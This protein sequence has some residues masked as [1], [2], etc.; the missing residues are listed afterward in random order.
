[1]SPQTLT[2][3]LFRVITALALA[4]LAVYLF[5]VLLIVF[6]GV[7]LA[8]VLRGLSSWISRHTRLP[9][10]V[11]LAAVLLTAVGALVAFVLLAS[12]EIGRQFDELIA[13]LP[14]AMAKLTAYLEQ[15]EWG[16]WILERAAKA[17]QWLAHP[18]ALQG[19]QQAM[20]GIFAVGAGLV[21]LLFVGVYVAAQ[22]GLY[23]D[24]TLRLLPAARRPRAREVA[25]ECAVTLQRWMAGM[26]V[27]MA[28]IG[29]ATWVGLWALGVSLAL[30][31]AVLAAVLTFIP[32]FGPIVAAVP[33]I[34]LGLSQGTSTALWVAGLYVAIQAV[35]SNAITP[36]IQRRAV[37]LPPAL[38]IVMQLVM[39]ALAGVLGVIMAT[40]LTAVALVLVRRLH[41]ERMDMQDYAN[42]TATD[43][44]EA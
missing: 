26:V 24:N 35:E 42:V 34:L 23:L 27:S 44:P 22:P 12:P 5:D 10:G 9:A 6:A 1:M 4:W 8:V 31:L 19:A 7:L 21:V 39:G 11:S 37:S 20:S 2:R 30:V 28:I 25:L 32:N 36:L 43:P 14:G 33:A 15:S 17:G 29:V 3:S 38:T 40:P 13:Q 16:R 41:V 18:E